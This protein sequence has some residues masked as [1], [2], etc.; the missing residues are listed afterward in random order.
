MVRLPLAGPLPPLEHTR[1][2]AERLLTAMERRRSK[3]VNFNQLYRDFME[4][5]TDLQHMTLV[6]TSLI[7]NSVCYLPHHGVLRTSSTT[8]KLRIVFNGSQCTPAGDSLNNTLL[9]EA[10][11]LPTLADVLLRWRWH[12]FVFI[13]DIEKMYWQILIHPDDRDLQRILWRRQRTDDVQEYRLNTVTYGLA[14]AP[15]LAIRTL[16]QLADDEESTNPKGAVALRRDCYV[17][18]IVTGASTL[19]EAVEI[20]GQL[21]RLCMAGGFPLRK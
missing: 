20:Q 17:D 21:R 1:K 14:C 16:R 11:L 4:E 7:N 6:K 2:S 15:F 10:N 19:S 8:T 3:D 9:V 12:R 18:D 5:Y 13:A